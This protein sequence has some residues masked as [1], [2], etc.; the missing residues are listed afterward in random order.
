M[1]RVYFDWNIFSGL[2]QIIDDTQPFESIRTIIENYGDRLLFPYSPAHISDL[3]RSYKKSDK[4]QK[5]T[6]R[7]L[8]FLGEI[9]QGNA[10]YEDHS[11]RRAFPG[12]RDPLDYFEEDIKDNL[13][14]DFDIDKIFTGIDDPEIAAQ[15]QRLLDQMKSIPSGIDFLQIKK[16]PDQYVKLKDLFENGEME[17]SYYNYLKVISKIVTNSTEFSDVYKNARNYSIDQ[18]KLETDTSR[19]GNPF[20][21]L[22]KAL[23]GLGIKQSLSEF[24]ESSLN[25][26]KLG[27]NPTRFETFNYY[28]MLL[29]AFGFNRDS[30]LPNLV[31]DSMHAYYGAYCDLFVT[32][33]KRAYRKTKAVYNQL[34]IGTIV[35]TAD[36]FPEQFYKLNYIGK[37][38]EKSILDSVTDIISNSLILKETVDAELNPTKIFKIEKPVISYFNRLQLSEYDEYI[39]VYLYKRKWDS[40]SDFLFWTELETITNKIVAQLGADKNNRK[41]F[42]EIDKAELN[43]D[44]WPGRIWSGSSMN[45]RFS[46]REDLSYTITLEV[47]KSAKNSPHLNK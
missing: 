4:G 15:G 3:K 39:G 10:L 13:L 34:N 28:Y 14:D 8:K 16:L 1:I 7:D 40:Y 25:L 44:R 31:D 43:E 11:K 12:I 6:L 20:D 33:D 24:V 42:S 37:G 38:A 18:M 47:K 27:D 2:N 9:T 41:E 19:W 17:D 23:P 5:L 36:E 30:T 26:L 32:N 29:D 21:Y 46:Y 35:C 22:E 45:I